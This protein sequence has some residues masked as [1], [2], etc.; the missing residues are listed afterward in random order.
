DD[1]GNVRLEGGIV[2]GQR[3]RVNDHDLVR[4]L[5]IDQ[6]G[7]LE[8]FEADDGLRLIGEVERG[9]RTK[10]ENADRRNGE[11]KHDHPC[12]NRP[13]R[14]FGAGTRQRGGGEV[15][16][17]VETASRIEGKARRSS[18]ALRR[19]EE[20]KGTRKPEQVRHG[21]GLEQATVPVPLA[22]LAQLYRDVYMPCPGL[23]TEIHTGRTNDHQSC[24]DVVRSLVDGPFWR[25]AWKRPLCSGD[26]PAPSSCVLDH[27]PTSSRGRNRGSSHRG[28]HW[29]DRSARTPATGSPAASST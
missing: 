13:P 16:G 12:G 25:F 19:R 10:P 14:M 6:A 3:F 29:N 17:H 9:G 27:W 5:G 2:H 23:K 24:R 11:D 26:L 1:A 8:G 21:I 4:R 28:I 20:R 15:S 7:I 18:Q 22:N